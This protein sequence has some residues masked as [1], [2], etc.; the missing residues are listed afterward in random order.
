MVER[1]VTQR[2]T[3]ASSHQPGTTPSSTR[4]YTT[5]PYMFLAPGKGP[6]STRS[7]E[8]PARASARAAADPAG[9]AP[10]TTASTSGI[11]IHEHP[12]RERVEDGVG[13]GDD[14]EVGELHHRAVRVGVD[15]H[16]V[17][18]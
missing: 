11:G 18:G 9:P 7:T 14:G 4:G 1:R 12:G 13:V 8:R 17:V 5:P 2:W 10:T 16:D 15:A 3:G 6:R